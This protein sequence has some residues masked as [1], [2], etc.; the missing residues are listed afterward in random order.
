MIQ[1]KIININQNSNINDLNN[2]N[3]K[4]TQNELITL[5]QDISKSIKLNINTTIYSYS[6]LEK[7][8]FILSWLRETDNTNMKHYSIVIFK[9]S[10]IGLSYG[11]VSVQNKCK[12]KY[13]KFIL[14]VIIIYLLFSIGLFIFI[15]EVVGHLYLAG[16]LL[17]LPKNRYDID[18]P[19]EY[20][21]IDTF[22]KYIHMN[23]TMK[24]YMLFLT[25]FAPKHN[26]TF[27]DDRNAGVAYPF[28]G[29]SNYSNLYYLWGNE[30][31]LAFM[32]LSGMIPN[33]FISVI[34]G[35]ISLYYCINNECF[36]GNSIF[37]ISVC[38]YIQEIFIL[39]KELLNGYDSSVNVDIIQWSKYISNYTGLYDYDIYQKQTVSVLIL[40]YP[41]FMFQFYLYLRLKYKKYLK[42]K[43]I[44]NL[45]LTERKY[46]QIV[47]EQLNTIKKK[48]LEKYDY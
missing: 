31:S 4:L 3:D 32:Y 24:N 2:L 26:N 6:E 17:T 37:Y 38:I 23:K 46:E 42:K 9:E 30:Q 34:L 16:G 13:L 27:I 8:F 28:L 18:Y 39:V 21:Q 43:I 33:Y 22:D 47:Y 36:I 19:S 41:L 11:N 29:L 25:G 20:Y 40:L 48:I 45:I 12:C 44:F 35:I 1:D 15:H 14:C 5:I 10:I 7:I